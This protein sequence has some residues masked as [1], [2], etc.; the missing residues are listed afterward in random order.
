M[1][2]TFF[3]TPKSELV[4]RTVFYTRSQADRAMGR[5]I[6][7]FTIPSGAILLPISPA[8]LSSNNMPPN[9]PIPP[10]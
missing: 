1:V 6:D 7:G 3:K 8:R 9:E 4:R 10:H 2:E 5:Y